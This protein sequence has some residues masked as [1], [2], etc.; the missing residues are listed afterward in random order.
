MKYLIT[1][2]Q[3]D[4]F[5]LRRFTMDELKG[6]KDDYNYIMDEEDF[7]DSADR[8]DHAYG[9]IENFIDRNRGEEFLQYGDD[10]EFYAKRSDYIRALLKFLHSD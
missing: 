2:S 5:L 9:L 1:E 7:E 10:T 3:L 4:T 6:L 8:D